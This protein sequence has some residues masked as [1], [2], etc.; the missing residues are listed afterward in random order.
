[1]RWFIALMVVISMSTAGVGVVSAGPE[2]NNIH[3][4]SGN[5]YTITWDISGE[6]LQ[7]VVL[8]G[9]IRKQSQSNNNG[10]L[11]IVIVAQETNQRTGASI[12]IQTD[13]QERRTD[14][15]VFPQP[16]SNEQEVGQATQQK[17]ERWD[18]LDNNWVE[19]RISRKQT[20]EGTLV[21][22]EQRDPTRG[23][24]D[25]ETGLPE[26]EWVQVPVDEQG[27]PQWL[28]DSPEGA[29]IYM[30]KKANANYDERTRWVGMSVG[31]VLV[32]LAGVFV[33]LPYH[34]KRKEEDFLYGK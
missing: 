16:N 14:V 28:F 22:P 21:V 33:V 17:A 30:A 18:Q 8:S 12:F 7:N 3:M 2:V 10:T 24:I 34:R 9:P 32:V 29:M 20:D 4:V 23:P 19:T 11:E 6:S 26:G 27:K 15:V 1:M 13:S 25:P 5:Q 31:F